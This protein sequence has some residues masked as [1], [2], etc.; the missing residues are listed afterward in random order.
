[1]MD[2]VS[3]Y[4]CNNTYGRIRMHQALKLKLGYAA[5]LPSER[6][7]YRI[8]SEIGISQIKRRPHELT[9]TDRKAMKSDDLLKRDFKS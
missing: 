6:T 2:I 7:V 3:A 5:K 9:K 8:M 4:E 1:M